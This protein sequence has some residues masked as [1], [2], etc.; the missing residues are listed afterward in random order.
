M[1]RIWADDHPHT[2]TPHLIR[3]RY[4]V[5]TVPPST[6]LSVSNQ[7]AWRKLGG[8]GAHRSRDVRLCTVYST[9]KKARPEIVPKPILGAGLD[10]NAR[11]AQVPRPLTLKSFS[12]SLAFD[13]DHDHWTCTNPGRGADG[14]RRVI[15]SCGVWMWSFGERNMSIIVLFLLRMSACVCVSKSNVSGEGGGCPLV[16]PRDSKWL[17]RNLSKVQP[18]RSLSMSMA[19]V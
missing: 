4:G 2:T 1:N 19:W 18:S 13:H 15:H 7:T 8:E 11:S 16:C 3:I 5:H 14:K 10:L 9:Y 12:Q 17:A 6:P